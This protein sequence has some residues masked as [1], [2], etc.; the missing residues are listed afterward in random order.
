[1]EARQAVS[2]AL[3]SPV[4]LGAS[5]VQQQARLRRRWRVGASIER[6]G[7]EG[8]PSYPRCRRLGFYA[9]GLHH[10]PASG[11]NRRNWHHR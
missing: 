3:L 2:P 4:Q 6:N 11:S 10:Q 9:F 8:P 7:D 5:L 1:V